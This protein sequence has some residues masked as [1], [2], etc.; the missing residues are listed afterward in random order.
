MYSSVK[1]GH[2]ILVSDIGASISVFRRFKIF[3]AA[4]SDICPCWSTCKKKSGRTLSVT[5][6]RSWRMS[7]RMSKHVRRCPSMEQ[8]PICL[9]DALLP[10]LQSHG[11]HQFDPK[12][13]DLRRCTALLR[14]QRHQRCTDALLGQQKGGRHLRHLPKVTGQSL[15]AVEDM[16]LRL[17]KMHK[18]RRRRV[19][20]C[21]STLQLTQVQTSYDIILTQYTQLRSK[22]FWNPQ[23]VLEKSSWKKDVPFRLEARRGGTK[24][25][26]AVVGLRE[27][28]NAAIILSPGFL[29]KRKK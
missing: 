27:P 5:P 20:A 4:A 17:H 7:K 18:D 21:F 29:G 23:K 19:S 8:L 12:V 2:Q 22:T 10:C 13:V 6:W 24:A 3:K 1:R 15:D 9:P 11:V 26:R 16:G 28:P 14:H 25:S